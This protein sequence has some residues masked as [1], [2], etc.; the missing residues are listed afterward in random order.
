METEDD[1]TLLLRAVD[2]FGDVFAVV[3]AQ[4][5]ILAAGKPNSLS[6][7]EAVIGQD[8]HRIFYGRE[9]PCANCG[10]AEALAHGRPVVRPRT[11]TPATTGPRPCN[12]IYPL[13]PG[14]GGPTAVC[15]ALTLPEPG[16]SGRSTD[17]SR[18][19]L[20]NLIH[21]AADGVIAADRRGRIRIYNRAAEQI[22]GYTVKEALA[23][24]D[25]RRLYAPETGY[26]IMRKL[27]GEEHGGRG[28]LIGYA[29]DVVA[30]NGQTVPIKLNAAIVHE[31]GQEV[32]TIGFFQDQREKLR[33][34][35]ALAAKM[36]PPAP[37]GA[38]SSLGDLLD[39]LNQ[40]LSQYDMKFG[41]AAVRFGLATAAQVENALAKQSEIEEKTGVRVPI[42]RLMIQLGIIDESK[43]DKL[44]RM[45][46]GRMP[47]AGTPAPAEAVAGTAAVAA[48]SEPSEGTEPVPASDES[49][50]ADTVRLVVS[51]DRL[52]ALLHRIGEG[53]AGAS[54][55]TVAAQ[56]AA[57]GIVHGL[58]DP[59]AIARFLQSD[60][61]PA[62][63]LIIARGIAPQPGSPPE[64]RFHFE[65]DALRIGTVRDDGT[66]DW[67]NRGPLP[68]VS[69]GDL[70]CTVVPGTAGVP[71]TDVFGQSIPVA[72][73]A[74]S[75][76]CGVG[77][78]VSAD[79]CQYKAT[80]D[81]LATWTADG[82][83]AVSPTLH[84]G[85]DVG[86]ETGHIDFNGHVEIDG[87][88]QK[89]FHV[90]GHSLRAESLFGAEVHIAGDMIVQRGIYDSQIKCQGPLKVGH[91]HKSR[92]EM[93]E[94]LIVERE[95]IE[96]QVETNGR[97]LA[98]A[99]SI[100][101]SDISAK[102]GVFVQTIGSEAAR[103]SRLEVGIDH[104]LK[105]RLNNVQHQIEVLKKEAKRREDALQVQ[106]RQAEQTAGE[107]GAVAQE[108]DRYMVQVREIDTALKDPKLRQQLNETQRLEKKRRYLESKKAQTDVRVEKLL[109][110]D[111]A[112]AA[113]L[114][115]LDQDLQDARLG[116]ARLNEEMA[117]IQESLTNDIGMAVVK[118]AGDVAAGTIVCGPR[119]S[120][121]LPE[122]RQRVHIFET[123]APDDAGRCYWRMKTAPLR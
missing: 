109:A 35:Q 73:P 50:G 62:Q 100:M 48:V 89:G 121:T 4:H 61:P 67:K 3:T 78:E 103:P 20:M 82:V 102:R 14:A 69:A 37:D 122:P 86:L 56:M 70:L 11:E 24:F 98:G 47:D 2:A 43:R 8:C 58:V 119:A 104:R 65:T 60:P 55:E 101:A 80:D 116:L 57:A 96:S 13:P 106:R 52:E 83:L 76:R 88:I 45:Q 16:P 18:A 64:V 74:P 105:R 9:T 5:K 27:R 72:P 53:P 94:D 22:F 46:L 118:A 21:N 10:L 75:P 39:G 110:A 123:N 84:I 63:P 40:V 51:E 97:C 117:Q 33:L 120:L 92:I 1:R 26:E 90:Y 77:V 38:L 115:R 44:L 87:A 81:G 15:T 112:Q 6:R 32:A 66:T 113:A 111:E 95:I 85:G 30:K 99:A 42:G 34:Q 29:L 19:F 91:V 54:V 114:A 108:Q 36:G 71:G 93:Q 23:G 12:Y 28:R 59:G 31:D 107:L 41:E 49:G 17:L 79:G 68:Q 7:P 25:I